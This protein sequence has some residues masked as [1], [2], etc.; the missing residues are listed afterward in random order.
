MELIG[1][2]AD[3]IHVFVNMVPLCSVFLAGRDAVVMVS[4]LTRI[5]V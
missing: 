3:S 4:A 5:S 1:Q 2:S